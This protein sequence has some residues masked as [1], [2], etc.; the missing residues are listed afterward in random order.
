[1]IEIRIKKIRGI[2]AEEQEN[3]IKTLSPAARE[4]LC[5]KREPHLRLSS[6]VAYSLLTEKE[7]ADLDFTPAGAPIFQNLDKCISI[8]HS[9]NYACVAVTDSK[10]EG[11][12][13]DIEEKSATPRNSTRF[14]TQNEQKMLESGTAYLE[15]WTKKEALFKFLKNDSL[16]LPAIDSATPEK[17]GATLETR[18]TDEYYLTVCTEK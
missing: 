13:I 11:V 17:Y 16:P 7:R 2:S 12:G 8:S 15:I 14:L 6:I 10:S 9:K 3:I 5:K 18:E 1:M 4:R